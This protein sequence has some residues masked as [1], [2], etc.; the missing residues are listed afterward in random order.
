MILDDLFAFAAK[1]STSGNVV[2]V[3]ANVTTNHT[4]GLTPP[5][6]NTAA[7]QPADL[8]YVAAHEIRRGVFSLPSFQ[9]TKLTI[10]APRP[11]VGGDAYSIAWQGNAFTA[12]VDST[13][14]I[15]YGAAGQQ[16]ITISLCDV[17]AAVPPQ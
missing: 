5:A 17:S 8:V 9:S 6:T 2:T 1:N 16:F 15:V 3:Q 11:R 10:T 7:V 14:N 13:T 12:A 4:D